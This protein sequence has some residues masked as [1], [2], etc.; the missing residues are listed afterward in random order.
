MVLHE[1][2]E[3]TPASLVSIYS[4]RPPQ[5]T[6]TQQPALELLCLPRKLVQLT[7]RAKK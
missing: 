7:K 6:S 5:L 3:E 1:E 4:V 2:G